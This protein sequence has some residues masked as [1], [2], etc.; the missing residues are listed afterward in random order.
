VST[1]VTIVIP[2]LN[3]AE[4]L[5]RCLETVRA[6]DYP[7]ELVEVIVADGGST[8]GTQEIVR[9]FGYRVVHNER[10]LG[11]HGAAL[12]LEMASHEIRVLMA[13][14]NGFP[15]N[16]WLGVVT[17]V[18]EESGAKG[19]YTHIVSAPT[20]PPFCRY[21]NLLH[22]DPFSWFV[23][24]RAAANPRRFR[25]IY[26]TVRGG[27]RYAVY[28][29]SGPD[30]PLLAIAQAFSVRG[31]IPRT[32]EGEADDIVPVWQALD[33][34]EE[35]AYTEVGVYHHH[36]RSLSDFLGKYGRRARV[37]I[38]SSAGGYF[39]RE[40]MLSPRQRRRRLLWFPYS[41]SVVMPVI[42]ALRGLARDRDPVW[43][44]HPVACFALS[45]VMLRE[46]ARAGAR[47]AVRRNLGRAPAQG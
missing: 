10:R 27:A 11:E 2:V 20:D 13:A 41:L 12:G 14:D 29:F 24:G 34:G 33:R 7:E 9:S 1:P 23:Y 28:D 16:D 15:T 39:S 35:L 30:R 21:V 6:Q 3:E 43:L 19:V 26:P 17:R 8:D 32:E 37:A 46:L 40:R 38:E 36:V 44:Y 22:A 47:S 42:D 4:Q 5:P 18:F 45:V 31:E 25:E